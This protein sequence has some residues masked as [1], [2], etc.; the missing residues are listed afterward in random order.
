[1]EVKRL[2]SWKNLQLYTDNF[3]EKGI[4]GSVLHLH[5]TPKL[6]RLTLPEGLRALLELANMGPETRVILTYHCGDTW[7][8]EDVARLAERL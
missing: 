6:C 5:V 1:M 4:P 3:R 2:T 8:L 7:S